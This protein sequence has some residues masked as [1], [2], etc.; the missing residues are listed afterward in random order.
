MQTLELSNAFVARKVESEL[1]STIQSLERGKADAEGRI[2]DL[3]VKMNTV[4]QSLKDK[5][6][7]VEH[8]KKEAL[9]LGKLV[10][11]KDVKI[12]S[13]LRDNEKN[14]S[15]GVELENCRQTLQKGPDIQA[16]QNEKIRSLELQLVTAI[17]ARDL[18]INSLQT[19][20]QV[21]G[22]SLVS[23]DEEIDR[24]K[25]LVAA[26]GIK[27]QSLL[28]ENEHRGASAKV[29]PDSYALERAH[30]EI[31]NYKINAAMFKCMLQKDSDIQALQTEKIHSLELAELKLVAEIEV[32]DREI[33]SLQTNQQPVQPVIDAMQKKMCTLR[34]SLQ[35]RKKNRIKHEKNSTIDNLMCDVQE[36]DSESGRC[37]LCQ[38]RRWLRP[39][40]DSTFQLVRRSLSLSDEE[41]KESIIQRMFREADEGSTGIVNYKE[42]ERFANRIGLGERLDLEEQFDRVD[43]QYS[44]GLLF[45]EFRSAV[46]G[47]D[48]YIF[49]QTSLSCCFDKWSDTAKRMD[50]SSFRNACAQLRFAETEDCLKYFGKED[51][52]DFD[53]F[54]S[55]ITG[56]KS[57]PWLICL[58]DL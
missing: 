22:Q 31:E 43:V 42:Y 45:G 54:L 47:P 37:R 15:N 40:D 21:T 30:A 58:E 28:H 49:S 6:L 29:V 53:G 25:K 36:I 56:R 9:E 18:E 14:A 4:V 57:C 8:L 1:E 32:K 51:S 38:R 34:R 27:I 50:A 10:T 52:L 39:F 3:R 48:S 35:L 17:E 20:Q 46:L 5:E 24:L 2:K 26:N 12:Q 16:L 41:G 19:F 33:N 23:K 7:E 44:G 11:V 13:L 55:A